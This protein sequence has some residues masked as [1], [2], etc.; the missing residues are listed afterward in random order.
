MGLH[1]MGKSQ[2][3]IGDIV[4][5]FQRNVS[6]VPGQFLKEGES[7]VKNQPVR[8]CRLSEFEQVALKSI[9]ELW[10]VKYV[11]EGEYWTK[12]RIIVVIR[13]AFGKVTENV[14]LV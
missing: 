1:S 4:P 8:P 2:L 9:V 6:R 13:E 3:E 11:F 10:G 7:A 5:I 12:K 14:Q